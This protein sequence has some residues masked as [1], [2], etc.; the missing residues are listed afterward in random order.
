MFWINISFDCLAVAK[1]TKK[2]VQKLLNDEHFD[3][4]NPNQV[5]SVLL[6]FARNP[7]L[8]HKKDGSGYHLIVEHVFKIEAYIQ[9][10]QHGC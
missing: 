10:L 4:T 6:A 1:G 9:Y 3:W 8:F 2:A 7:L 5:R